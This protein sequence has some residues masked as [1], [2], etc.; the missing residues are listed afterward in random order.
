MPG[1]GWSWMPS[2]EFSNNCL[3]TTTVRGEVDLDGLEFWLGR[4]GW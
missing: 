2:V 4:G 1:P 3:G